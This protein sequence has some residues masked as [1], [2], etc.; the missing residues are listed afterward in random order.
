MRA[1]AT[2]WDR[3]LA[4]ALDERE[5]Q[6][7]L[8][9]LRAFGGVGRTV[10]APDGRELLNFSSNDYLGLA[11]HPALAEAAA[12]A[13]RDQGSGSTASRLM[14]GGYPALG[15]LEE[16]LAEHKG[17]EAAL[18]LGSG[19]LANVGVIPALAGRGDAVFSDS[20]NHA[21]T[22]DG[23][24]LSRADVHLYRHRDADHL[25]SLLRASPAERKL[26][27]TD[28]IFSMDGDVAPLREIA[29]L[30]ERYGAALLVDDAHGAGVFGPHGEGFAHEAGVADA[31]DL[32][33]G[34]FSKAYGCYGACVAG[35]E[36]WIRYLENTCRSLVYST[37]LPPPVVAAA[38]A[39]LA[40]VPGLDEERRLLVRLA[41][42]F[43]EGLAALGLDTCGSTTQIVPLIAGG[44]DSAL[45]VSRELEERGILAVAVR[46]PTV[47]DGTAR[48]RFSLTA[49]LE[50][51]D[52]ERALTAVSA[53]IERSPGWGEESI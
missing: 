6:G 47:P 48:L 18:V 11:G 8:R 1:L 36:T 46:P 27:V 35:R 45:A 15:E 38:G 13:A 22:V 25:E 41:D 17:T 52:V 40:L 19:F 14:V 30:K 29:G 53:S 33:M 39:A 16:N 26:I 43:R 51:N 2:E 49:A 24:R 34:T 23:C 10:V 21:S 3:A 42:R 4:T 20:L 32:H 7:L 9:S 5:A 44:A 12:R 31:V 37:A 28:T 50:D